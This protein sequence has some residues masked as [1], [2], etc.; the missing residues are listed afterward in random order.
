HQNGAV[1]TYD[2]TTQT[3]APLSAQLL[4]P[5]SAHG[6]ALLRDGR[7]LIAGGAAVDGTG[8][9]SAEV[10]DPTWLMFWYADNMRAVR[11]RPLLHVLPDGKVQVIG[12]DA[13]ST[14]E[15]FDPAGESFGPRTPALNGSS[16]LADVLRTRTRAAVIQPLNPSDSELSGQ[17]TSEELLELVDRGDRS[18]T[19]SFDGTQAVVAGGIDSSHNTVK[20]A[21]VV[22]SSLA[23]VTTDRPDYPPAAVVT[24]A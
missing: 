5:R 19:E 17:L 1:E 9:K 7:V 20:S 15:I 16:S 24:I 22:A 2:P 21:F 13:E 23:T 4:T 18:I 10:F 11:L 14:F 12:G 8:L 6:A 3:F